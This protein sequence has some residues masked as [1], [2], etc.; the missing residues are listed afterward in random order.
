M[1][2]R[3]GSQSCMTMS[4]SSLNTFHPK[5]QSCVIDNTNNSES[6][7]HWVIRFLWRSASEDFFCIG[8]PSVQGSLKHAGISGNVFCTSLLSIVSGVF[9]FFLLT[10]IDAWQQIKANNIPTAFISAAPILGL[11]LILD[12]Y[13]GHLCEA[14]APYP[15]VLQIR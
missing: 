3:L 9:A 6:M 1:G 5:K 2:I 4:V 15:E 11:S 13:V 12:D 14:L 7:P 10:R 8:K